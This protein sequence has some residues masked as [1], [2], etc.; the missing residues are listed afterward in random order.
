M[1]VNILLMLF[2]SHSSATVQFSHI[3]STLNIA[4]TPDQRCVVEDDRLYINGR[5]I[6]Y[7]TQNDRQQLYAYQQ[8]VRQWDENLDT[9]IQHELN[10]GENQRRVQMNSAFGPQGSF[11]QSFTGEFWNSQHLSTPPPTTMPLIPSEDTVPVRQMP[12]PGPP[13][14]CNL[15]GFR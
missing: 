8:Q 12:Y 10:E 1:R 7:L 6:R 13:A 15:A 4:R 2:V 9:K 11:H 5:F 3:A 14:F